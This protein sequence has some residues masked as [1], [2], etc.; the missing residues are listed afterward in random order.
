M[1]AKHGGTSNHGGEEVLFSKGK[2]RDKS[3]VKS[4]DTLD[5]KG[6]SSPSGGKQGD[7]SKLK[8]FYCGKKGHF[9]NECLKR[10]RELGLKQGNLIHSEDEHDGACDTLMM[11]SKLLTNQ[12][13]SDPWW[14]DSGASSHMTSH[15][16]YFHSLVAYGDQKKVIYTA[17][18][19]ECVIEGIG[20]IFITLSSDRKEKMENVLFIPSITENG[21]CFVHT[22]NV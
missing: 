12:V 17:N 22:F 10:K 20:S 1:Q 21:K 8:C 6:Y 4:K 14:I 18:D 11:S 7:R 3:K 16:E 15:K 9:S 2:N 5:G 19:G 13:G